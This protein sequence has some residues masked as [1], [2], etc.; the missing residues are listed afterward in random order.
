MSLIM[1]LRWSLPKSGLLSKN[2][3]SC[4]LDY[5]IQNDSGIYYIYNKP[6]RELPTIFASI[7]TSRYLAAIDILAGYEVAKDKLEFV[8]EWIEE[9]KDENG[10]WDLGPKVKDN[11]YF[12]LSDSWRTA[13]YR[14]ADCTDK[15]TSILQKLDEVKLIIER[16]PELVN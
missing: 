11:I 14:K 13:E 9:N 2:T 4:L 5:V 1:Q 16:K 10:Q 6:I 12:P 3:A 15:I 7:E 8:V